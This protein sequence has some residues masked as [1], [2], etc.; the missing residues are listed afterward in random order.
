[1]TDSDYMEL[2]IALAQKGCGYTAPNPM[3][4]AIIVKNQHI[5]GVGYHERYGEAHA[6]RN[7]LNAC[8]ES[9]KDATIY[10]TL[11]PCPMCAGAIINAR[12]GR[13]IF[14]AYDEK[15]GCF[16]SVDNFTEKGFN[17]KVHTLGGFMEEECRKIL[18]E[19]FSDKRK[20]G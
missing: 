4:G 8:T 20:K 1:M 18:T 19:L 12:I 17:H 16:G 6:E 7:A 11:E 13:V 14:G 5:I 2:A 3:V 15:A 10:V 9:P